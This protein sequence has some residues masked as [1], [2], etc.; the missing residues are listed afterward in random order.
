MDWHAGL[1]RTLIAPLWARWERSGYLVNYH[2][3]RRSQFDSPQKIQARQ[4]TALQAI[5]RHAYATVP[6]YRSRFERAGLCP[7]D[8]C[9]LEDYA[10]LPLLTKSDIRSHADAL[11]SNEYD[12]SRLH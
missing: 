2:R 3:L 4:W 10:R 9:N 12:R 1:I 8:F 5:T 7:Q 6:F 11:L